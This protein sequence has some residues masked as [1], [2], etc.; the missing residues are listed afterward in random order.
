MFVIE[1]DAAFYLTLATSRPHW[2][3]DNAVAF[4]IECQ[5]FESRPGLIFLA[6]I[7]FFLGK[8]DQSDHSLLTYVLSA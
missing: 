8:F 5:E 7:E 1:I 3:A 4:E 6:E 2:S